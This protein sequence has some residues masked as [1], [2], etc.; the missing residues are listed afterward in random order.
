MLN[1][2]GGDDAV[3]DGKNLDDFS[4]K[5]AYNKSKISSNHKHHHH[6]PDHKHHLSMTGYVGSSKMMLSQ[7]L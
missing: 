3:A 4:G 5:L 2:P 1:S 6:A 7:N